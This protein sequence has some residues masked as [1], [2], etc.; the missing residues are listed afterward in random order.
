MRKAFPSTPWI[1]D[2]TLALIE[3]RNLAMRNCNRCLEVD[4]NKKIRASARQDRRDWLDD[5]L[6]TGDWA[7]I[8]KLKRGG[9][10]K[11]GPIRKNDGATVDSCQ[12]A[13]TLAGYYE[14]VQL[15]VRPTAAAAQ[16]PPLGPQLPIDAGPITFEE[17]AKAARKMK[18]NRA[19]GVDDLLAEFW[20]AV[21]VETGPASVWVLE[22]CNRCWR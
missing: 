14:R 17:L 4:L 2:R 13:E 11:R 7:E 5:K 1:Q 6:A 21:L 15:A 10:A 18:N 22:F 16:R 19:S 12:R 9:H 20:K 8:R 3:R